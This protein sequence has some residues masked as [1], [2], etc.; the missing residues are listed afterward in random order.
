MGAHT[1]HHYAARYVPHRVRNLCNFLGAFFSNELFQRQQLDDYQAE[2][3]SREAA[4]RIVNIFIGNT[5]PAR[6]V[7]ELQGEQE[8]I[9]RL[10]NASGAAI[11]YQDKLLLFGETPTNGQIRELAGWLAGQAE[12]HSYYTSKLSLNMKQPNDIKT[13][14]G[15]IYVAISPGHHNYMLWFRP[16]VVQVV[17]WAGDPAK[18]VLKTDDGVRLSPRKSFE[19]GGRSCN[20]LPIHGQRESWIYYLY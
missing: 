8:P 3:K 2:I 16:E 13:Q 5:S 15:V 17:E 12:D 14:P 6:V 19:N 10:M 20:R 7:E 1:C 11:C 9:L 18:A 4:A